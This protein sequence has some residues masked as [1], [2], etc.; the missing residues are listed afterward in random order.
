MPDEFTSLYE[1]SN[2]DLI[3]AGT[4]SSADG[5]VTGGHGQKDMWVIRLDSSGNLLAQQCLGG[6]QLEQA[7]AVCQASDG[8]LVV[9]GE[10]N[11]A[12][13][14]ISQL[15]G[16][17][18]AWVVKLNADFT[19]QWQKTFGGS[20][21]DGATG[22]YPTADGGYL[23]C[24]YT[25]STDG[26]ASGNRGE[27]DGLILR[28]DAGGNIIWKRCFGGSA[29]EHLHEIRETESGEIVLCGRT[30]SND[31]DIQGHHSIEK[32]KDYLFAR[33]DAAGNTVYQ[34]CFGG[35]KDDCSYQLIPTLE[36]GLAL[37]GHSYS[38][39]GDVS[40]NNNEGKP[41]YWLIVLDANDS[42]L[43]QKCIGGIGGVG[44]TG[45]NPYGVMQSSDGG[46]VM[47]GRS[48][49]QDGDV[50]GNHGMEDIWIV[51]LHGTLP[52]HHISTGLLSPLVYAPGDSILIPFTATG[53]F[54]EGNV[55]SAEL[56]DEDGTFGSPTV[57]GTLEGVTPGIISA[58]IPANTPSAA[59]YRI[60]IV[61]SDPAVEGSDN[62]QNISIEIPPPVC[63]VP[64]NRSTSELTATSV[65]LYWDIAAAAISYKV[66]HKIT[67]SNQ[68]ITSGT[69]TNS[70]TIT[71]LSANTSYQWQVK[72]ICQNSPTISSNWS[73][74]Q[75]FV[76]LSQKTGPPE[77]SAV[78]IYPNPAS[79]SATVQI[80]VHS[81]G[82][83]SIDVF[84][85]LGRSVLI[86]YQ[87]SVTPGCQTVKIP[88]RQLTPGQYV[89]RVTHSRESITGKL[90]IE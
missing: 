7:N 39:D 73:S 76:T 15:N 88:V 19:I 26:D 43:W 8:G 51:K 86:I 69:T 24:C 3:L 23:V 30:R 35:T 38:N 81:A 78:V 13:G 25:N 83:L 66:R 5:D 34:R 10:T 55:F 49:S 37:I 46:F 90:V 2:G 21:S 32:G 72:S 61:S 31:G 45:D 27:T 64:Q 85:A 22:V 17:G 20:D 14:D 63:S 80:E 53:T 42:I 1:A 52:A 56:S 82:P 87:P 75:S 84:D 28:L 9:A 50:T 57:I 12:D 16:N 77:R 11:S 59:G 41:D 4:T 71:G 33:L 58:V 54:G 67:G 29:S 47:T 18:D 70:K 36:G 65:Q 89:V 44:F 60:R 6:S 62:G 40:G 68:W 48:D 74:K 79:T